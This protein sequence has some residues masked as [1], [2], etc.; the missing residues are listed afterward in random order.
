MKLLQACLILLLIAEIRNMNHALLL[1]H[2]TPQAACQQSAPVSA[3]V[4]E[5]V[6]AP[7]TDTPRA[8][9]AQFTLDDAPAPLPQSQ[10]S[11]S[12]PQSVPPQ[13]SGEIPRYDTAA[14]WRKLQ[15]A[16]AQLTGGQA[17]QQSLLK[18][19]SALIQQIDTLIISLQIDQQALEF[20]ELKANEEGIDGLL[21]LAEMQ[22]RMADGVTLLRQAQR[23]FDALIQPVA[24]VMMPRLVSVPMPQMPQTTRYSH[25]TIDRIITITARQHFIVTIHF[26]FSDADAEPP[27]ITQVTDNYD[28]TAMQSVSGAYAYPAEFTAQIYELTRKTW[29]AQAFE[30]NRQPSDRDLQAFLAVIN[31]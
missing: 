14:A 20:V 18:Q 24:P 17:A 1:L 15:N 28:L 10:T 4:S 3:R 5:P 19:G 16:A 22:K 29:R 9:L 31:Q 8:T 21:K 7:Q 23:D 2:A 27:A 26:F 25:L 13:S 12:A 30:W 6:S 11:Q